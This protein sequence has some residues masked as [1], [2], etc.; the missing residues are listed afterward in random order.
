MSRLLSIL[1]FGLMAVSLQAPGK[2][3]NIA[4]YDTRDG[5]PQV[6][7]LTVHQCDVGYIW[8]GTFSGLSRYDGRQFRHF[9]SRDGLNSNHITDL[10]TDPEGILWIGTGNGVCR[11]IGSSRFDC[12]DLPGV[13]ETQVH[14]LHASDDRLWVASDAG[15]FRIRNGEAER[16]E[17]PTES[18]R[19]VFSVASDPEGGIWIGG[20]GGLFLKRSSRIQS[21]TLEGAESPVSVT[22]LTLSDDGVWVG[23]TEGLFLAARD[24]VR[25]I[26]EPDWLAD[27]DFSHLLWD[28]AGRLWGSTA[29]GLVRYEQGNFEL[30]SDR[31][32][33]AS[34]I[35]H[36]AFMDREGIVWLA[37]DSG[38]SKVLPSVFVGYTQESGLLAAFVRTIAEDPQGRLWLG[39]RQ[40]VQVIESRNGEWQI[41]PSF[42]IALDDGLIDERIY[43]IAFPDSET[44]LLATS[45]GVAR[46]TADAGIVEVIRENDGLPS[47]RTRSL[48]VDS[49]GKTWISTIQGT[50]VYQADRIEPPGATELASAYAIRIREDIDGRIWFATLH[51]G[52]LMLDTD[53]RFRQWRGEHGLSDEM[54]WDVEPASDGTVWVGSNGDGLFQLHVDGSIRRYSTADGLVDEF[55]WQVLEDQAGRIWA[56]TNRGLSRFDGAQWSN[57]RESDGLLHMEGAATAAIE[58]SDGA[59]WFGS[60]D[61]LMRYVDQ[62]LYRPSVPPPAVVGE[63][64]LGDRRIEPGERLPHR[65]GSLQFQFAGLSFQDE[66]EVRFRYR[67]LD[68]ENDWTEADTTRSVTYAR[69]GGGDYRFEVMARSP[70]GVWSETPARFDFSVQPPYWTTWW[71]WTLALSATLMLGWSALRLRERAARARELE[72]HRTVRERT[73]ELREANRRLARASRTD[74]LTG[75]PNRRYLMDRIHHDIAEIRRNVRSEKPGNNSDM[76]FMMVDLDHF[77]SINDRFGH[78]A[79]DQVLLHQA[80]LITKQ[81]READDLIRWGGEEFLIV[82]RHAEASLCPTIANRIVNAARN[83]QIFLAESDAVIRPTCS[84]GIASYPFITHQPEILDWEQ[85]VQLADLAMYRA[86]HRGRDGWVWIRPG[87]NLD[88]S[89]GDLLVERARNDLDHMIEAGEVRIE[90]GD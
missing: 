21:V 63:V 75:L 31:N 87:P 66:S 14:S 41:D 17:L 33:L 48:L 11:L 77:K 90:T 38:L 56:Y 72:L 1:V 4:H 6:Q 35:L 88:I 2:Q 3:L 71:F 13:A 45:H 16:V 84:I 61:G 83:Q 69:L 49:Q 25:R 65:P 24:G 86:K 89:D 19:V 73:A 27:L 51:H 76:I 55:V 60:A 8:L 78:A 64:L 57:F 32:R 59:L 52:L 85:T 9:V 47:N 70:L 43:S 26:A 80:G 39:T 36:Q 30:L 40:G 29:T 82:A 18:E 46:W 20:A 53:G 7:V 5:I 81:L 34:D 79:G 37:H 42:T 23:T 28:R 68:L 54:L 58:A 12:L 62:E 15:L 10:V 67:L 44:A 22:A 50:V 74:Q